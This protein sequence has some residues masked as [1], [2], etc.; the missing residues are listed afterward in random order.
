RRRWSIRRRRTPK[1]ARARRR[2]R[3][4]S[5]SGASASARGRRI[6]IVARELLA[7]RRRPRRI[8][9]RG[10]DLAQA[11]KRL[12]RDRRSVELRDLEVSLLR[13]IPFRRIALGLALEHVAEREV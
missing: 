6:G 2:A 5:S 11:A 8:A 7:L 3:R 1:R 13:E 4:S 10:G 12:G 9:L